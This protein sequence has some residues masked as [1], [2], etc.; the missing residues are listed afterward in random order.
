MYFFVLSVDTLKPY[1]CACGKMY[2]SMTSYRLHTRLECG[3]E[4]TFFC[5]LC[6]YKSF[7]KFSLQNHMASKH[8]CLFK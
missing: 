6:Q 4:P 7:R 3:K 2:G 8:G 5:T 1:K